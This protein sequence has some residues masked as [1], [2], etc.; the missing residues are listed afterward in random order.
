[1]PD[2]TREGEPAWMKMGLN[3][4]NR[5]SDGQIGTGR[6]ANAFLHFSVKQCLH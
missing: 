4:K 3:R 6:W 1:M 2:P 5:D